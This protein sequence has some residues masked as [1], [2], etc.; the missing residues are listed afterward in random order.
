MI[1]IYVST[2]IES[3]GP[4]PGLNS[5]LSFASAA[6][7]ADKTLVSTFSANLETLHSASGDPETM[8]W[9]ET[10][11]EAWRACRNNQ[12]PPLIVMPQYVSWLKSLS[13]DLV[14]VGY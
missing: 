3:D 1:E 11:P 2:D 13:A 14:F 8:A 5:M 4:V 9:W 6:F 7:L 10:K 12:Q